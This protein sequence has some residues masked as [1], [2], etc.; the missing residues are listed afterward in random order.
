MST[1]PALVVS[2]RV[3]PF[4]V[5][6]ASRGRKQ[7]T[8]CKILNVELISPSYLHA[9]KFRNHYT[10]TVSVLFRSKD[11]STWSPAVK[12]WLCMKDGCHCEQGSQDWVTLDKKHFLCELQEVVQVKLVLRQP[13][14]H[15]REFGVEDVTLYHHDNQEEPHSIDDCSQAEFVSRKLTDMA[16]L[17]RPSPQRESTPFFS[18]IAILAAD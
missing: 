17:A 15:W 1:N 9:I 12:E 7:T 6:I 4:S 3:K 14:P 13:S 18:D 11:S 5:V 2:C 10:H 8:G 16:T